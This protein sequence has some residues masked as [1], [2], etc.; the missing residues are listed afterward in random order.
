MD[1]ASGGGGFCRSV[2]HELLR[3]RQGAT[4]GRS[5]RERVTLTASAGGSDEVSGVGRRGGD[6][7]GLWGSVEFIPEEEDKDRWL[8]WA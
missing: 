1:L 3:R 6:S 7:L 2:S 4:R 8:V 5:W